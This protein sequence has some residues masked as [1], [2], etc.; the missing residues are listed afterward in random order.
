ML[1]ILLFIIISSDHMWLVLTML[2]AP[3]Y[4]EPCHPY[5][6]PHYVCIYVTYINEFISYHFIL[7]RN[8]TKCELKME[9]YVLKYYFMH[10]ELYV[11]FRIVFFID[12]AVCG[13]GGKDEKMK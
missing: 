4:T 12:I 5:T 8:E 1:V 9:L 10:N 6:I 13:R 3:L 7:K 11:C 2:Y